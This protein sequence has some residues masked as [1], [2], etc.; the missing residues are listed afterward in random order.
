MDTA[1]DSQKEKKSADP[2]A[3]RASKTPFPIEIIWSI[4]RNAFC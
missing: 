3:Q 4:L 1:N 2:L